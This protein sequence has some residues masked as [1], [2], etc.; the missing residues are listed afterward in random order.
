MKLRISGNSIRLR[1]SQSDVNIL[2]TEGEIIEKLNFPNP[3]PAFEYQ[4]SILKSSDITHILFDGQKI[5]F[6]IPQLEIN[7]W[8]NSDQEGIYKTISIENNEDLNLQI[9]KDYKCLHK[10]NETADTFPNPKG[11]SK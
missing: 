5:I 2:I 7:K 10:E 11:D 1:L 8:A 4:L 3:S 6:E 9:E